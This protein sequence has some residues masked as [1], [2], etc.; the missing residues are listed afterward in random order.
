MVAPSDR[1]GAVVAARMTSRRLPGKALADLV[2]QPL[3]WHV[4]GSLERCRDLAA[5]VVA[6]SDQRADD[7]IARWCGDA[8]VA[9]Y[10]GPLEDVAG[11]LAAAAAAH[12][13]AAVV[14]ISGDSPLIDHRLVDRA[15]AMLAAESLEVV[16]NVDPRS[17]PA[18]QSVEVLSAEAL[19]RVIDLAE[20][21]ADREHVTPAL[22]RHRDRFRIGRF[23]AEPPRP[24]ARMTVD[25]PADLAAVGTMLDGL[26]RPHWDYAW[27]ELL[28][29]L[30]GARA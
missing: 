16:T 29:R 5:L 22:Y 20:E 2:G 11:R 15:V 27:Q 18:G 12:D 10:R 19:D 14:R 30:D 1:V 7:P 24:G 23:A 8:G 28:P 21:P 4:L 13:L 17:F 3:L 26:A 6:T 25:T 9:L